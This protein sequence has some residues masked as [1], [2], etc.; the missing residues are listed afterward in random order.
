MLTHC[1]ITL[2]SSS[3]PAA[4]GALFA[5]SLSLFSVPAS[6]DQDPWFGKDKALHFGVSLAAASAGYG[7]SSIWLER[8]WQRS[9][10]SAAFALSLGIGKELAD[11]AGFGDPSWKDLTWDVAGTAVG[12]GLALAIDLLFFQSSNP[13]N[14]PASNAATLLGSGRFYGA[15]SV[16]PN[17]CSTLAWHFL[18]AICLG[19]TL[20]PRHHL[21]THGQTDLRRWHSRSA[22]SWAR[23]ALYT[24]AVFVGRS[25]W[26]FSCACCR[27]CRNCIGSDGSK[28]TLRR[29]RS[30]LC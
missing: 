4:C 15:T 14:Q 1:H 6:A 28:N 30:R 20:K 17:A 12:V 27:L 2:S 10:T 25:L 22:Q 18:A 19:Q 26:L 29:Q 16:Q 23:L 9:V 24:L 7:V 13:K 3:R 21:Q 5:L 11:L 8:P